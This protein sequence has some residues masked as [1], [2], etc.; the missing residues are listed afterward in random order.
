MI[1]SRVLGAGVLANIGLSGY[2]IYAIHQQG[3]KAKVLED[4]LGFGMDR[5]DECVITL[6]PHA[7]PKEIG[8]V[9]NNRCLNRIDLRNNETTGYFEK[10]SAKIETMEA[11]DKKK[12]K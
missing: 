8:F 1:D 2:L 9:D 12:K 7:N 4:H 11:L 10:V 6:T 5:I 3:V